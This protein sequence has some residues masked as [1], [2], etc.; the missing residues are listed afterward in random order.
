MP[1]QWVIK[2]DPTKLPESRTLIQRQPEIPATAEK[3][4]ARGRYSSP[5]YNRKMS[6][7]N[8]EA[9][10]IYESLEMPSEQSESDMQY[11]RNATTLER[12]KL[13]TPC[14][15]APQGISSLPNAIIWLRSTKIGLR[16]RGSGFSPSANFED[17]CADA[18]GA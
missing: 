7:R 14:D 2:P 4:P 18:S 9:S 13:P 12:P 1:R 8:I 16:L 6:N 17:I 10:D 11:P 3:F 5:P 15:I